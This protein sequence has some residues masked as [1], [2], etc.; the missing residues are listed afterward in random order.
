MTPYRL[1]EYPGEACRPTIVC[2]HGVYHG[3]WA[4]EGF[5]QPL[6]DAGYPVALVDLRGHWGEERLTPAC[7][8]G[9]DDYLK[10]VNRS[11]DQLPGKKIVVGHSLGGL[12]ALSLRSRSD[13]LGQVL[14]AVPLPRALRSKQWRLLVEYPFRTVVFLLTGN[15]AGLYHHKRFID[16]YFFSTRTN[17][18][19]RMRAY[20]KIRE[21]HEPARLFREIMGLDF[22]PVAPPTP[23]LILLGSEDPTVTADVG[24]ELQKLTGGEIVVVED[25]GH[26]VMLE[27][28]ATTACGEV[29][30][31]LSTGEHQQETM[32]PRKGGE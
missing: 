26:D 7:D 17:A 1:V 30:R 22:L 28:G 10:D 32:E 18:D 2:L 13:V 20:R 8:V 11:L 15:A 23:T 27:P 12:L 9:Y 21:Q 24:V 14:I 5:R 6:S 3:S 25:A 29:L 19:T 4:F 31:W 16:K